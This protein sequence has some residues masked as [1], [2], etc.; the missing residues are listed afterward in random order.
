EEDEP[1]PVMMMIDEFQQMGAMPYLER[2]I[3]TLRSYRGHVAIIAQSLASLDGIYGK[4]KRESLENGAGV[5]LYIAPRDAR[6]IQEL[7]EAVGSTTREAVTY[8]YGRNRGLLG[9]DST[10]VRLEERPL[11]SKT[12]ARTFDQDQVIILVSSQF[13]IKCH[14]IKDFEDPTFIQKAKLQEGRDYPYP[15]KHI[16]DPTPPA[17]AKE[18]APE[19][20]DGAAKKPRKK[21][22]TNKL[23]IGVVNGGR[24][25]PLPENQN[26]D[27]PLTDEQRAVIQATMTQIADMRGRDA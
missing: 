17:A 13:P 5:K 18:Q 23:P 12:E 26:R 2:A 3:H 8:S 21:R 24:G 4:E 14:R 15:P 19:E 6:T 10:S 16:E 22:Q 1:W 7:S 11:L 25:V 9:A 20:P 27:D